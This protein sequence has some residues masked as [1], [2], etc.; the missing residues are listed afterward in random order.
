M[1]EQLDSSEKEMMKIK[2][3]ASK[4]GATINLS[5]SVMK[6]KLNCMWY[7]GI[8]GTIDYKDFIVTIR[9]IGPVHTSFYK[10]YKQVVAVR[11]IHGSGMFNKE[12]TDYITNDE[13]LNDLSISEYSNIMTLDNNQGIAIFVLVSNHLEYSIIDNL[14]NKMVRFTP[15]S[16]IISTNNIVDAF[17]NIEYYL[18]I[19]ED[20]IEKENAA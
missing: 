14:T 9:A 18:N 15:Y 3:K 7:S 17:A 5:Q 6:D 2:K 20:T 11:D 8:I 13:M 4:L 10:D 1:D 16:N 12:M 19:I